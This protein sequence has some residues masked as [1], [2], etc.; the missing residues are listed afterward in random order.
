M[1]KWAARETKSKHLIDW[2]W[3]YG[4]INEAC[5]NECQVKVLHETRYD[6]KECWAW[7]KNSR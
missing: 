1:W 3:Y 7:K 6:W 4:I 5:Y 2:F